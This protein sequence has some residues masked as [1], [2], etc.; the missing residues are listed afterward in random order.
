MIVEA[1]F[2]VGLENGIDRCPGSF[3]CVL[4]G[5]ERSVAGHGIAQQ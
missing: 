5:E 1:N 2:M 4:T 3:N